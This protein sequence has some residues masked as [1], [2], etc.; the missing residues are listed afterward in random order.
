MP[1]LMIQR[2][3]REEFRMPLGFL[4]EVPGERLCKEL[5]EVPGKC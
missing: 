1:K 2:M 3:M 4:A 5:A